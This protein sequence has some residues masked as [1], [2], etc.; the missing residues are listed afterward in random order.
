MR[1]WELVKSWE[2]SL[3]QRENSAALR[4]AFIKEERELK[5]QSIEKI[6]KPI[7]KEMR[8]MAS[9]TAK[10][11]NTTT[12]TSFLL[13][14]FVLDFYYYYYLQSPCF[15]FLCFEKLIDSIPS[16][17]LYYLKACEV[18]K[19]DYSSYLNTKKS[20]FIDAFVIF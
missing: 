7:V 12:G 18:F 10:V 4:K 9:A 17:G 5:P 16:T 15:L 11:L 8:K 19:L 6:L 13:L 2:H 1:C 20:H 14:S 3:S